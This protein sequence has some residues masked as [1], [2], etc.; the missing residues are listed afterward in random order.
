MAAER[1][2]GVV[3]H[4]LVCGAGDNRVDV[5]IQAAVN[6]PVE[7]LEYVGRIDRIKHSRNDITATAQRDNRERPGAV[8]RYFTR[9]CERGQCDI[10]AERD[11]SCREH[12]GIGEARDSRGV[13]PG[14]RGDGYVGADTGRFTRT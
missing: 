11:C 8:S 5:A 6:C 4:A 14:R 13:F 9:V 12:I 10:E 2:S 3:D 1:E 7:A